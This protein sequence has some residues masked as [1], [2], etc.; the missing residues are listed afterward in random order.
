MSSPCISALSSLDLSLGVLRESWEQLRAAKSVDLAQVIGQ[1]TRAAEYARVVRESVWS[2]LPAAS[3]QD[4]EELDMHIAEI[5]KLLDAR[6]LE[7]LRFRLSALATELERGTIVHRRAHRLNELNQLREQAIS[8]LRSQVALEGA[9]PNLPGPQADQWIA[10]ACGLQESDDA[11]SLQALRNG[12]PH[13][14]DFVANLEPHLW[15][16]TG[17]AALDVLPKPERPAEEAQSERSRLE[18][19]RDNESVVRSGPIP[20]GLE[21]AGFL[22]GRDELRAP[23][24]SDELPSQGLESNTLTPHDVT[25]PRTDE[26]NLRILEQERALLASMMNMVSDPV[27]H[28]DPAVERPF[29]AAFFREGDSGVD[30]TTPS[31]GPS[32]LGPAERSPQ[33]GPAQ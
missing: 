25:P 16:A 10:W 15:I 33:E 22:G 26:D 6:A 1:L 4:R 12:F 27:G 8:E 23:V 21:D 31:S 18:E 2:E 29:T 14:D 17:P 32:R 24:S 11:E 3:W 20:I 5:Q 13:L 7:Q 30:P 28:F 9:P 19:K